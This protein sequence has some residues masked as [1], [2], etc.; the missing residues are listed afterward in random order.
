MR[1]DGLRDE[2]A[3]AAFDAVAEAALGEELLRLLL[4]LAGQLDVGRPF[5]PGGEQLELD[6]ADPA[7]DLEDRCAGDVAGE[8][9]EVTRRP[10]HAV[11][12]VALRVET[13]LLCA[14]H[15]LVAPTATRRHTTTLAR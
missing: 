10:P 1:L 15:P 13:R 7:A 14:E 9:D 5:G 11:L 8:L 6:R 2:I 12:A 3:D 4:V